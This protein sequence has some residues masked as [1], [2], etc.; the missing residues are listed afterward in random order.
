M[1][2]ATKK[3]EADFWKAVKY[4]LWAMQCAPGRPTIAEIIDLHRKLGLIP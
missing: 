4:W 2:R 1:R 3:T